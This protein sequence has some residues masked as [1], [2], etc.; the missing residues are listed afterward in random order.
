MNDKLHSAEKSSK[1]AGFQ[2]S[3]ISTGL[4]LI[5]L[6][7]AIKPGCINYELVQQPDSEEVLFI[8][9]LLNIIAIYSRSA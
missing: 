9:P 6:I 3:S 7:D 2:D 8:I 5:D 4:P 1:V